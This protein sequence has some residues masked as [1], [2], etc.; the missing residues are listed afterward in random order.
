MAF[1]PEPSPPAHACAA[2]PRCLR[3]ARLRGVVRVRVVAAHGAFASFARHYTPPYPDTR[4]FPDEFSCSFSVLC[5]YRYHQRLGWTRVVFRTAA[6]FYRR[7]RRVRRMHATLPHL[8]RLPPLLYPH[9]ACAFDIVGHLLRLTY[10]IY[11][12]HTNDSR[13]T[14]YSA[15]GSITAHCPPPLPILP[16]LPP[17]Q[18]DRSTYLSHFACA[19]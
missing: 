12:L 10:Q 9:T 18:P 7:L 3:S 4:Q 11:G 8:P 15:S 14:P 5:Y 1:F 2:T 13:S 6:G 16:H 17:A 19:H